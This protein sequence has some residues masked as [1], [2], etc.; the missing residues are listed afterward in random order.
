MYGVSGIPH[1][2]WGGNQNVVGGGTSTYGSYLTKYNAIVAENAPLEIAVG[3]A[4]GPSGTTIE[5][6]VELS[7][8]ITTT[9]NKIIFIVSRYI[10]D[11]YFCSVA[12]YEEQAFTLTTAGQSQNYSIPVTLNPNWAMEDLKAVVIVQTFNGNHK[13]LNARQ[14]GFTGLLPIFTTNINSGPGNLP[15]QFQN[16]SFPQ[17]GIDA[18]DWDLDGD[19]T[20]DSHEEDPYFVYETA[21][22]YDVTLTIHVGNEQ[23]SVTVEDAITVTDGQNISGNLHGI[24]DAAHSPYII[25][26]DVCVTNN[27]QLII[28][29]GAEIHINNGSLFEV[30]G[31]FQAEA[32]EE[33]NPIIFTSD[34]SWQG[35][36]FV[37]ND[38]DNKLIGCEISKATNSA[39]WIDNS[40]ISIIGNKIFDNITTSKAAGIEIEDS[41]NI[42]IMQNIIA[43]NVGA[44]LCGGIGMINSSPI[45]NNNIIVNNTGQVGA[46]FSIKQQSNPTIINN[47]IANNEYTAGSGGTSF[48]FSSTVELMNNIVVGEGDMIFQ[49]SSTVTAT[50]NNVTG[51]IA[52]TG[53]IDEDPNFTSPTTGSGISYNGLEADW[54]L[55]NGSLC[56]DA[57]NPDVAYN[58]PDGSQ[59]D[60]G[61]YGGP[62]A[63]GSTGGNP[64]IYGDLDGNGVVQAFDAS[65][66]LQGAV[67][68]TTLTPA[69]IIAADVDGNGTIMAYDASLILQYAVG[70]ITIFPVEE[71]RSE[72]PLA[73]VKVSVEDN[74]LV[75]TTTGNLF[76]FE[77]NASGIEFNNITTDLLFAQNDN[78]VAVASAN[79]VNG[80]FLRIS[81]TSMDENA[82]LEMIVNTESVNIQLN[83]IPEISFTG[84]YPNPFNPVCYFGIN[85]NLETSV[86]INIYNVK[87]TKVTT[88]NENISKGTNTIKWNA[89]NVASGVYFYKMSVDNKI[90][91]G[92]MLLLK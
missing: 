68:L 18:F 42:L 45:I 28:E 16:T 69:Q 13:I 23:E 34:D 73:D 56:I 6:E 54:T 55:S 52:G 65:I 5:A 33:E 12:T 58:D 37:I 39:I 2:Q 88:I 78:L 24:W 84:Q 20:I 21:G 53:N 67:G 79:A 87:G 17:I 85:S 76:G 61:A 43:N 82:N 25:T 9:N 60:M 90:S 27:Y 63:I 4:A 70:I 74:D 86:Q 83:S 7:A 29:P 91:S 31:L 26:D 72:A 44:T 71:M 1:C 92:K 64:V 38:E 41:E 22:T 50:Y 15:V 10:E 81:F 30:R 11:S 35:F 89:E 47:T 36:K 40:T 8:N 57:G 75:F 80:E 77:V 66:T 19:G 51:G 46:A 14:S 49:F 59:N 3:F 48:I 62:N 32:L